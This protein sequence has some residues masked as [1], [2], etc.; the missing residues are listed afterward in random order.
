MVLRTFDTPMYPPEAA[1]DGWEKVS[2][3]SARCVS[4]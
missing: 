4:N 1:M 3:F 2:G